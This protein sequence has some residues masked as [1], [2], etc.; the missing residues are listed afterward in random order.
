M[1]AFL[2]HLVVVLVAALVAAEVSERVGLPTVVGEIVAG[3]IIGPSVLHLVG[4]DEI[5]RGLAE[6]GVVVL[7]LEVGLQMDLRELAAV[8]RASLLVAVVGVTLPFAMGYGVASALGQPSMTAIFLGAALTATSVGITARVF[9]DLRALASVEA[10]TVLGAAV[11]DDILGL[12][13]LTVVVRV[14]GGGDVTST[15]VVGTIGLAVAFLAVVGGGAMYVVPKVIDWVE[16]HTRSAATLLVLALSLTFAIARL[17]SVAKLAPVVGAFVAGLA[18]ARCRNV[19][20]VRREISPIAHL[21][22]PVFFLLIGVD[23]R[24]REMLH[25]SVLGLAAALLAV[26]VVG[27]VAAGYVVGR[28]GGDRLLIGLGMMPRGEV[29]LIFA[30]LGLQQGILGADVYGAL[31]LVVLCTTLITPPVLRVRLVRVRA[32]RKA[33]R[34]EPKPAGGWLVERDGVVDL[35][36]TP[37]DHE[38]LHVVLRA[39]RL[40][41]HASPGDRLLRWLGDESDTPVRWDPTATKELF[42]V[43]REGDTRSW[44]LLEVTGILGRALPELAAS[45]E[46][47]RNDATELDPVS[48]LRWRLVESVR[49]VVVR[50][51][52]ARSAYARLDKPDWLLLAALVIDTAHDR[53]SAVVTARRLA[54]RLDLGAAAEQ[55]VAALVADKDLLTAAARRLHGY[56]EESVLELAVHLSTYER[57][58]ALYI[59]SVADEELEAPQRARLDTLFDLVEEALRH[60]ELTSRDARNLVEERR[61]AAMRLVPADSR[62]AARI[63]TAP[64]AYVLRQD[65]ATVA[66]SAA[67]ID[68]VPPAGQVRV[69][70]AGPGNPGRID[71]VAR[72]QQGLLAKVTGGL[73]ELHVDI[74]DADI[75]TWPDGAGLE[76]FGVGGQ[77]IPQAEAVTQAITHSI[78]A[79]A[80][81]P[82]V[83]GAT[84]TYDD[85]ASPWHTICETRAPDRPGLL[86]SIAAAFAAVGVNV[87][88]A[89]ATTIDEIVHD[90]F[91][92]T[93]RHGG[94]LDER[95]KAAF[96]EALRAGV[97]PGRQRF[98]R[99][100]HTVDT[101][102][103]HLSHSTET[104]AP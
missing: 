11:A 30:T 98:R 27:K 37:P 58:A 99:V 15:L 20:R 63:A 60:P 33:A 78:K 53:A 31:L 3:I 95:T 8:G 77:D 71:V 92:V 40:C 22:I 43:L 35:A 51:N 44:R 28:T 39:A 79:R 68:P 12:V 65:S 67:L 46:R 10:R 29:G 54:Q 88:T 41:A 103:K 89:R 74:A 93:D 86:H 91:A 2:F 82:A 48:A 66:R 16:D 25:P 61:S 96:E 24:I 100:T 55:H 5:L 49:R 64:R 101:S 18:L 14:A 9:G 94:K 36:A 47:R 73:A 19:D 81:T 59:L 75:V 80:A 32:A 87:H 52:R 97:R 72:D 104:A 26:A 62:A 23:V 6:L 85:D 1:D 21:F 17:A 70:I 42:D 102:S 84:V 76:S 4:Q 45:L 57:A 69:D 13:V 90:I 38:L 50:D 7:L 34:P 56:S 83:V